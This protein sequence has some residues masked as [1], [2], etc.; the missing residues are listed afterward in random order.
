MRYPDSQGP[1]DLFRFLPDGS[2]VGIGAYSTIEICEPR[3]FC[4]WGF[5]R[6]TG[7]YLVW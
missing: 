1:G 6:S 4:M 5:Q 2:E 3:S 7:Y